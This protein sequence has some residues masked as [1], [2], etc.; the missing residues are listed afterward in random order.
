MTAA[1][2]KTYPQPLEYELLHSCS[3][4]T[5]RSS[6]CDSR[7]LLYSIKDGKDTVPHAAEVYTCV[8]Q[9]EVQH[10]RK[11]HSQART[12]ASAFLTYLAGFWLLDLG[13]VTSAHT[14]RRVSFTLA[15]I[16]ARHD[17]SSPLHANVFCDSRK[18]LYS[19][20]DGNDTV[21]HDAVL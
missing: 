18:W 10:R 7:K 15:Y 11:K 1:G 8:V 21:P 2:A 5:C 6:C 14:S 9:H 4:F 20:K 12:H 16:I 17:H 13:C 19:I 3:I